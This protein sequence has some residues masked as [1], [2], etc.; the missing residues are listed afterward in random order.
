MM[1]RVPDYINRAMSGYAAGAAFLGEADPRFGA[2][3][4]RYHEYL[5]E[6]RSMPHAH[7]HSAAGEPRGELGAAG[8]SVPRGARQGGDGRRHRHPRLPHAGDA[9]D[10]RRDHG[11]SLDAAEEP[12][13]GRAVRLRLL[14]PEPHAGPAVHLPRER[15][16]RALAFRP[17]A[18]LAL[19]GNGR[20]GDL[21]RRVRALGERPAVSRRQPLQPGLC[22]HRRGRAHDA[23]GR[24]QEHRQGRVHARARPPAGRLDR[25]RRVSSTSRRSSPSSGSTWRR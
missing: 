20:G 6:Q 11:V 24:G 14:D 19:R 18:R 25:R 17:P 3:A 1:G 7:A 5:R 10:L 13:G 4:I 15:R 21:R 12:R 9:A 16:L 8:R 2:N 23:S 22:A